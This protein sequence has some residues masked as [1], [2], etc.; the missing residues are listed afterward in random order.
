MI[1]HTWE[2][3]DSASAIGILGA[4]LR[5][6]DGYAG[7][8]SHQVKLHAPPAPGFAH[9]RP[10]PADNADRLTGSRRA[11]DAGLRGRAPTLTNTPT[12]TDAPTD[13]A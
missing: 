11:C 3:S 1:F 10:D 13:R 4:S 5:P 9:I 7:V 6:L 2:T 12:L 8:H